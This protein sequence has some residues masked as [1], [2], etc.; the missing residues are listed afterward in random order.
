VLEE[1]EV[2]WAKAIEASPLSFLIKVPSHGKSIKTKKARQDEFFPKMKRK[3]LKLL[4][5]LMV[6]AAVL[7][8]VHLFF[9]G[10]LHRHLVADPLSGIQGQARETIGSTQATPDSN[11]LCAACQIARQGSVH[12]APQST[13]VLHLFEQRSNPATPALYFPSIFQI[14]L[15]GRDP[16][17]S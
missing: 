3:R 1:G 17:R 10:V 13:G 11:P 9:V 5:E 14:P 8:Q 15:S 2:F 4:R 6:W 12:P 7:V 16:P